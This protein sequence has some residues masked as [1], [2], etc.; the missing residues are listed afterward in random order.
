MSDGAVLENYVQYV[1]T[2]KEGT[3]NRE[4]AIN[5]REYRT[6]GRYNQRGHK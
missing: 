4:V 5:E 6:V 1:D 2:T 3:N